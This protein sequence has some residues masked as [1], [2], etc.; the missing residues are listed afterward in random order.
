MSQ[1]AI[2]PRT[3]AEVIEPAGPGPAAMFL[4]LSR[5][6]RVLSLIL[7]IAVM[8]LADL[9]MTL[10][11]LT[12]I[13]ML[14][15]NPIARW[16]MQMQSPALLILWKLGTLGIASAILLKARRLTCGEVAA[17]ICAAVLLWLM[18][19]WS[20]YLDHIALIGSADLHMIAEGRLHTF[21]AVHPR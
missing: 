8:S 19:R 21:V 1:V 7:A 18:V 13:G 6:T 10:T 14:E 17:W 9:G 2:S 20:V 15:A 12:T 4:G 3:E 16:I 5:E 11:H